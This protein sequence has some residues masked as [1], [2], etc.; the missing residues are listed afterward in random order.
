MGSTILTGLTLVLIQSKLN[1][2]L[3][4]WEATSESKSERVSFE[5]PPEFVRF[6]AFGQ[7]SSLVDWLWI[8]ALQESQ[9]PSSPPSST[10]T[11]VS[12]EKNETHFSQAYFDLQL[13]TE[14]DP[15][16]FEAYYLG[17]TY[18]AV[19]L[20]DG[21][22]AK[23]LLEKGVSFARSRE[24]LQESS[25]MVHWSSRWNLSIALAYVYLFE[26]DD[27]PSAAQAFRKAALMEGAPHYL[28]SLSERLETRT[29]QFEVGLKLLSFLIETT[30]SPQTIARLKQKRRNL[31][32]HQY[33]YRLNQ[34]F[35]SFLNKDPS[36]RSKRTVS[37]PELLNYWDQFIRVNR[38]P[39]SD[40]FGGKLILDSHGK[41]STTTPLENVMRMGEYS[42]E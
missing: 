35:V 41:I 20:N 18:L 19:I 5:W 7:V 25:L 3:T 39:A 26:L 17:G 14:L 32:L 33:L 10:G 23:K 12:G 34:A 9:I 29:G 27:L 15:A 40:P 13:I 22:G 30:S 16:F 2:R 11:V 21:M 4:N 37:R 38:I 42:Y 28:R 31:F 8:I 24:L 36:Y 1:I 6:L